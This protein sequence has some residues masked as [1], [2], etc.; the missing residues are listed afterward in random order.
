VYERTGRQPLCG[1]LLDVSGI[2]N[3]DRF[4]KQAMLAPD[5]EIANIQ[6]V[7]YMAE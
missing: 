3:F 5:G 4:E 6:K 2:I 7:F 1:C